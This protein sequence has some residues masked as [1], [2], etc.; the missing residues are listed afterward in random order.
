MPTLDRKTKINLKDGLYVHHTLW[1][2]LSHKSVDF[3]GC[4]S[5]TPKPTSLSVF[6]AGGLETSDFRFGQP[7]GSALKSGY[8]IGP[9]DSVLIN[10][11]IVNNEKVA[12][13]LY[14]IAEMEYLPGKPKDILGAQHTVI[15]LGFCDGQNGLNIHAPPGKTK[16]SLKGST[17]LVT[18]DGWLSNAST[19]ILPFLPNPHHTNINPSGPPPRRRPKHPSHP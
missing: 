5:T 15:D 12:K 17:I 14:M 8:Y 6:M 9:Q 4:E 16:W 11:D 10:I 7:A 13:D 2:D 3:M 18:K 19:S 1:G